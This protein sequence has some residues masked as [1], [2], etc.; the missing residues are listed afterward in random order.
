[1]SNEEKSVPEQDSKRAQ[2]KS[3][4]PSDLERLAR[5][6]RLWEQ[7]LARDL[8]ECGLYICR[9]DK[10]RQ[11]QRS[12][13]RSISKLQC[14]QKQGDENTILIQRIEQ[15]AQHTVTSLTQWQTL[16]DFIKS[17]DAF[18]QAAIAEQRQI[19]QADAENE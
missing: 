7:K 18:D 10:G 9:R 19:Q 5:Q 4:N 17:L 1:M 15:Q 3:Q 16:K 8:Q 14:S 13:W 12:L 11:K 6:G 2:P